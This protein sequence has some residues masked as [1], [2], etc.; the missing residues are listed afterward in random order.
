MTSP[1]ARSIRNRSQSMYFGDTALSEALEE[2]DM[3]K[4]SFEQAT[5]SLMAL[6]AEDVNWNPIGG[7]QT[8]DDQFTL[9][10]LHD[11][12]KKASLQTQG[13][14]LLKQGLALISSNV[15]SKGVTFEGKIPARA[16]DILELPKNHNVLFSQQ[17]FERLSRAAFTAGTVIMAY[18]KSTKQFFPIPF[19]EITSSASNP[20]LQQ[21]VWY[22]Q[23]TWQETDFETGLL[24][25][26][27]TVKWFAVLEVHEDRDIK[28]VDQ[29]AEHEVD[30]DVIIIDLKFNT[31]IGSIWGVP[32]CLPAMPYAWAHTEY[33]KDASKLLKALSTIAWKVMA[34]SK[35][36]TN[37]AAVKMAAPK[38]T[39]STATMSEGTDLVAMPK[40]GQVDMKDGQTL[41]SY[42][43]S[44]LGVSLVALLSDPGAASGSYG[45]AAS[46]DGPSANA[47]RAR[48]AMWTQFY[49]RIYRAVGVKEEV[50]V[51]FPKIAEDP[52]FRQVQTLTLIRQTGGMWA[53]EYRAAAIEA[54]D[55]KPLHDE[56][57]DVEE[58]A[59][60]VN[61]L[62][63]LQQQI[64][65]AQAEEDARVAK[66]QAAADAK[67]GA[68]GA[69]TGVGQL[70]DGD[71]SNRDNAATPG[72]GA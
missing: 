20:D 68:Q 10:N 39:A 16:K 55:F 8:S 60:S 22:Y 5:A 62:Q 69:N 32:D 44:S 31:A 61:G 29:I 43:A 66:E 28:V 25:K 54:A 18:R 65:E 56:A 47:A 35:K 63:Y 49:K 42:V 3:L 9:E 72:T 13:N 50:T 70:A 58:Y 40:A 15:F 1:Q 21:D 45:A 2:N 24:R 57:P 17:A 14:P 23:R 48:Q 6:R 46:L 41:A 52:T 33:I 37:N 27:P 7:L 38:S 4:E 11:I 51:N 12:Y 34:K 53:D 26:Q 30:K 19:L 59:P 64:D 67:L 36:N 71:N